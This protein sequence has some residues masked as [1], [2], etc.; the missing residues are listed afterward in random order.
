MYHDE[1][2]DDTWKNQRNRSLDY[3]KVVVLCTM[4]PYASY[5]K[6]MEE[7]A[8]FGM[9]NSLTL[10]SLVWKFFNSLRDESDEP[11]YTYRDKNVRWFVRQSIKR[12]RCTALNQYYKWKLG[13]N[14][15]ET[16]AEGFL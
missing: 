13:E 14:V 15:C 16:T 8:G 1:A 12:D 6:G 5:S 2:S 10:P 7:V 9:K 3:I 4:F 11:I